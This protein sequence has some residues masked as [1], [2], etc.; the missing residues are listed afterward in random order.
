MLIQV[1]PTYFIQNADRQF[2]QCLAINETANL[3]SIKTLIRNPALQ[4]DVFLRPI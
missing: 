3:A 1:T 2:M 4:T